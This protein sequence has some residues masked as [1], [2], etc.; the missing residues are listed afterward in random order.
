MNVTLPNN[1]KKVRIEKYSILQ[2][3]WLFERVENVPE[4]I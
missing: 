4:N 3:Y 2:T 1:Y